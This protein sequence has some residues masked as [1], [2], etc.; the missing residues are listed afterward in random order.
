MWQKKL[1]FFMLIRENEPMLKEQF[2]HL[3]KNLRWDLNPTVSQKQKSFAL[4]NLPQ[5]ASQ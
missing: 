4:Y 5:C 2:L 1:S 3:S